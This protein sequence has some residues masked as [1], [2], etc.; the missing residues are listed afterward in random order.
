MKKTLAA[1]AVLGAF[2]GSAMAADVSVYGILDVGFKYVHSD[3]DEQG[4][5]A[6]DSFTMATGNQSGNRFGLKGVEDL[7][8]G[9]S[10]GFVLENGFA[11]D[12][13]TLGQGSRLFGREANLFVRGAFGELS[14][15]RLGALDS[16]NGSYGLL[17]NLSPFGASW[18]G[19]AVEFST[20]FVGGLR[21]DNTVTYKSPNFAGFNAY[22]QYSFG[23]NTKDKFGTGAKDNTVAPAEGKS[24]DNRYAALGATYVAGPVNLAASAAL[25]NWSSAEYTNDP[26]NGY[27]LTAGGYYNCGFAKTYLSAQYFDNM[28]KYSSNYS[29]GRTAFATFGL[30]EASKGWATMVGFDMPLAGGTAMVAFGYTSTE[31]ANSGKNDNF[32][33]EFTRVGASVGYT[34]DL[35]KRTNV[36]GV[37]GYYQDK[38]T[39]NVEKT[40]TKPQT[41]AV[42]VGMRHRF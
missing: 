35:S 17:G 26:D 31:S 42:Y 23:L 16:A 24:G 4:K 9:L 39:D 1:L 36:Y 2:A 25:Y 8:N 10:V 12:D 5:D 3:P 21:M 32:D 40:E 30:D 33:K 34:Y 28:Y 41:T 7:G 6:T 22:A 13:G 37:A 20:Y 14:F 27:T 19:V 38:V 11:L 18:P 29:D 15:G